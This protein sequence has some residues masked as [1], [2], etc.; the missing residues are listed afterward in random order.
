[1]YLKEE[2]EK[3]A[4]AVGII[5]DGTF[6][7]QLKGLSTE[8]VEAT[9]AYTMFKTQNANVAE[10]EMEMGDIYIYWMNACTKLG[11]DPEKCVDKAFNK[12]IKRTGTIVS[13]RYKKDD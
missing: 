2:I 12:V 4:T 11:L 6:I 8:V 3:W 9:E 10:I 7:G 1:M 5:K 13:G